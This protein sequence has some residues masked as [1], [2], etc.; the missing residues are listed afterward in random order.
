MYCINNVQII[1]NLF[2]PLI[3]TKIDLIQLIFTKYVSRYLKISIQFKTDD[4]RHSCCCFVLG[5]MDIA[6]GVALARGAPVAPRGVSGRL[7]TFAVR[8]PRCP[9]PP[10]SSAPP[11][12]HTSAP[13]PLDLQLHADLHDKYTEPP[14]SLQIMKPLGRG[15]YAQ[16]FEAFQ[17]VFDGP[18]RVRQ[19]HI[20]AVKRIPIVHKWS[21][22]EAERLMK[23]QTAASAR[24]VRCHAIH[25]DRIKKELL[26]VME[27]MEVLLRCC[28]TCCCS[29]CYTRLN[30]TSAA[31]VAPHVDAIARPLCCSS[32]SS[33]PP[34]VH[35]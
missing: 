28:C 26:L 21:A 25:Y 18:N 8:L 1:I 17:D 31:L 11:P 29:R 32:S 19:R 15:N 33:L 14:T 27:R 22:L 20:Y 13:E 34:N 3:F 2:C 6:R 35:C 9:P 12:Q 5:S 24:I 16:V 4:M 30:K 10:P 23:L 7:W